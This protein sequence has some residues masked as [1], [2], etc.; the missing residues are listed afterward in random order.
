VGR[1]RYVNYW[2]KSVLDMTLVPTLTSAFHRRL[3]RLGVSHASTRPGSAHHM[4]TTSA[5]N[6]GHNLFVLFMKPHVL[7]PILASVFSV[8]GHVSLEL[9]VLEGRSGRS[10]VLPAP[11]HV[12]TM[13][14]YWPAQSSVWRDVSVLRELFYMRK[15]VLPSL[16]AL[17][18]L[19]RVP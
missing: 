8:G 18:I 4:R 5:S 16:I 9:T 6:Q 19:L 1:E 2:T 12:I 17:I 14:H 10:V 3:A 13:T 11:S 15:N 7:S